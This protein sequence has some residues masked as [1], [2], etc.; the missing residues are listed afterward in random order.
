MTSL[1]F[2]S[3]LLLLVAVSLGAPAFAQ[4]AAI[5]PAKTERLRQLMDI[6]KIDATYAGMI[7]SWTAQMIST[8]SARWPDPAKQLK[9]SAIIQQEM[10]GLMKEVL[11][12]VNKM[13]ADNYTVAELDQLIAFYKSPIGQKSI[14]VGIQ[15]TQQIGPA[16]T[17][18]MA[19]SAT[20]IQQR[21]DTEVK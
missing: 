3:A 1:R 6:T 21:L 13:M 2:L 7:N 11:G 20:R 9:A 15:V 19:T 18:Q 4:T 17:Q 12:T 10:S 8:H 16:M 14:Q 5:D